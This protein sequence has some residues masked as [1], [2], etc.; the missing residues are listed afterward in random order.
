MLTELETMCWEEFVTLFR[1]EDAPTIVVQPLAGEF[2]SVLGCKTMNVVIVGA[3]E[4]EI[5]LE[6]LGQS[7]A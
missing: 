4:L 6:H 5:Y 7:K 3:S 1:V 2:V